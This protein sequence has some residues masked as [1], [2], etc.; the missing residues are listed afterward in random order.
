VDWAETPYYARIITAALQM[1]KES[2][3][4][5]FRGVRCQIQFIVSSTRP[6]GGGAYFGDTKTCEFDFGMLRSDEDLQFYTPW[7]ACALVHEATHGRLQSS[8]IRYTPSNR[9]R[10]EKLCVTEE[11]RFA[12]RLTLPPRVSAWL[13]E[14]HVFD[15]RRW[16]RSWKTTPWKKFI[17]TMRRI[18]KRQRRNATKR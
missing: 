1:I 7:Y 6:F 9:V 2:D 5:R 17:L 16:E 4:R 3:P 15:P 13:Q 11:Q 14:T 12:K 18:R 10:I 8:G